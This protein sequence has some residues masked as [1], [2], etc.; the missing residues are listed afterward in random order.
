MEKIIDDAQREFAYDRYFKLST[1]KDAL[2]HAD[3][4]GITVA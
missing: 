2:D 3:D 4:Y 1:M